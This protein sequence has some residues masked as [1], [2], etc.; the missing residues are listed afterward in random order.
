MCKSFA[1][2]G[3]IRAAHKSFTGHGLALLSCF[4]SMEFTGGRG[5]SG[6]AHVVILLGWEPSWCWFLTEGLWIQ[7]YSHRV[8]SQWDLLGS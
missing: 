2:V 5:L 8:D 6:E 3:R 4:P 1:I 7:D